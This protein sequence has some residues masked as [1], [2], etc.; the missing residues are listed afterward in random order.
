MNSTIPRAAALSL[1]LA[2]AGSAH[3]ALAE[4]LAIHQPMRTGKVVMVPVD[5]ASNLIG[6]PVYTDN[7][8]LAGLVEDLVLEGDRT[9][10]ALKVGVGNFLGVDETTVAVAL[11]D[12]TITA[13]DGR[14]EIE[15][16]LTRDDLD[17]AARA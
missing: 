7:Q 13:D 8:E 2:F 3:E 6:A 15:T 4:P 9:I 11:K 16:D 5:L 17:L 12:L 1:A 14:V 10:V